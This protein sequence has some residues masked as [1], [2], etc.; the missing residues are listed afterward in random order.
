MWSWSLSCQGCWSLELL[1][2]FGV[3]EVTRHGPRSESGVKTALLGLGERTERRE[4]T[5]FGGTQPLSQDLAQVVG[6]GLQWITLRDFCQTSQ[7]GASRTAGFADVSEAAFDH[8]ATSA[9]PR[10][11]A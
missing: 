9:L 7:P 1:T 10:F 2:E 5:R 4:G 6:G 3:S 11:A 8:F